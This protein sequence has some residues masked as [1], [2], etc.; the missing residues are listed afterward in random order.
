MKSIVDS[1]VAHERDN[2]VQ[3]N[4]YWQNV[5]GLFCFVFMQCNIRVLVNVRVLSMSKIEMLESCLPPIGI[6]DML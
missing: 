2:C 1:N 4:D 5:V 3:R 6:L